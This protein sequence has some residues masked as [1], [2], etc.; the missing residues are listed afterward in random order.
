MTLDP[1][2][3]RALYAASS[4]PYGSAGT[5]RASTRSEARAIGPGFFVCCASSRG[6]F[7]GFTGPSSSWSKT[8][9]SR[10]LDVPLG[11]VDYGF[12]ER[13]EIG[14][15]LLGDMRSLPMLILRSWRVLSR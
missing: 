5:R 11:R 3:F 2:Y 1:G 8:A 12:T 10:P 7:V 15:V 9:N 4:D 14:Q 13:G 6:F